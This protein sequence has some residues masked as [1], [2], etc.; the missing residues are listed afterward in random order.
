MGSGDTLL[1]AVEHLLL[2][3]GIPA[4]GFAVGAYLT[5]IGFRGAIAAGFRGRLD[6]SGNRVGPA[7]HLLTWMLLPFTPVIFGFVLWVLTA[8][9][10]PAVDRVVATSAFGFGTAGA[11]VA[12]AQGSLFRHR[13]PRLAKDPRVFGH[14]I[15]VADLL[16]TNA[17]FPLV[18]AFLIRGKLTGAGVPVDSR[19]LDGLSLIGVSLMA[20]ALLASALAVA[21]WL[22]ARGEGKDWLKDLCVSHLTLLPT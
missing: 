11:V 10:S 2:F 16:E 13:A 8:S 19:V 9:L 1:V 18:I 20:Y 22:H 7:T 3:V 5:W 6:A 21:I 17:I 15:V 12:V 14:T 4:A